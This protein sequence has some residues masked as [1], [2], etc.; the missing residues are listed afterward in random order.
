MAT[1]TGKENHIISLEEAKKLTSNFQSR[2]QGDQ[3]RA[4]YVSKEGLQQ[5]LEQENCVGVRIYYGETD[6]GKPE[7]VLVGVTEDGRDLT[8]GV[9]L[10]RTM[11]CPPYCPS[12][13]DLN[14]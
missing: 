2:L 6:D 13:S 7:L 12:V 14:H 5:L 1:F 11:P 9:I 8:E 3:V 4:H 10:E